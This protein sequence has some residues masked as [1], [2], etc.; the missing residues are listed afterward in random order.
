[1]LLV[2]IVFLVLLMI[3]FPV[4]YAIGISGCMYFLQNSG[5]PFLQ[6]AQLALTQIQSVNLLAVPLFIFAGN[7]MNL[8]GITERLLG[9]AGILTR[10][11]YGGM[12]QTSVVMSTLMGGVSGSSTADAAM[13]SRVLGPTMIE[14]GYSRGYTAVVIGF[15]SLITSTIPPGVNLIVYGTSGNVSIGRLFMAG[16]MSGLYMMIGLMI[17]VHFTSKKRN[18]K[19]PY[20]VRATF[21]EIGKE[22]LKSFWALLFPIILLVGIRTGWFTASEVGSFA[23]V[24]AMVVGTFIYRE[25]N[26]RNFLECLRTSISDV[27]GIMF[28][29][30]MTGIFGYGIPVDKIP[31]KVTTLL[32]SVT[33]NPTLIL[34][35][36]LLLL[37][38]MGMFMDGGVIVL[39]LT[40]IL[41]P[42]AKTIGLDPVFFGIVMCTVCCLGIL[43]PPVGVAMYI[44]CGTLKVSMKEWMKESI[45]FLIC[46]VIVILI[47]VLLPDL[48]TFLPNLIYK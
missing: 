4:A 47:L 33:N 24:Y 13:E 3:G 38:I 10:H 45:P 6:T 39:L 17:T 30:S 35:M 5:I 23:C 26:K 21:K 20:S 18:Y 46:I 7:L 15:T 34:L 43:T 28:M 12:A 29:I 8:C 48:V 2:F 31:Q 32:L 36:I 40:P 14:N 19:P 25:V 37:L 27:G 9:L 11:M 22:T 41:L 44:V 42:V 1:M 16:L